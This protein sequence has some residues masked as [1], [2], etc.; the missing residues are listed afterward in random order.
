M[1]EHPGIILKGVGGLYTVYENGSLYSCA[2]RGVLRKEGEKLL[3][4]DHVR[5]SERNLSQ[6][7]AVI[8]GICPRRNSL[9]RPKVAN[10]D[11]L[12]LL[13]AA[14]N[15]KPDLYL[16]D[17]M[18]ISAERSGILPVL[19]INKSDQD[20]AYARELVAQY[21][22][23]AKCYITCA[24]DS[25]GTEAVWREMD[26][27]TCVLA[28]QSGV[29]KSTF[30]NLASGN[31]QMAT[32]NLSDKTMRGKHTTRHAE[33]FQVSGPFLT[34]PSFLIDSPGFSM[35]ELN[36]E[37]KDL[38]EAYPEVY[39][40]RGECRFQDCSHTSEPSCYV[41]ALVEQG[42]FHPERYKRYCEFYRELLEKERNKYR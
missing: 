3:T 42:T 13:V 24:S 37:P 14:G 29:G 17:K 12:F 1:S 19:V 6:M 11:K 36:L 32:G 25:R 40:N 35:L 8:D 23:A 2:A 41:R 34:K 27:A 9:V 20:E 16:V 21:Q 5:L 7:T 10:I 30:L 26:G 28:G 33:L 18:L 38:P 15:P 31:T 39:N 22:N 4:G